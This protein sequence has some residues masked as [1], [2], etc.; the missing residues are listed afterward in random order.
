[1]WLYTKDLVNKKWRFKNKNYLKE[2]KRIS[3][4]AL[5]NENTDKNTNK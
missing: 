5:D 2:F 3:Q 1:M 4:E